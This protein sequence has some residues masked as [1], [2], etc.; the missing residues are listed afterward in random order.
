MPRLAAPGGISATAGIIV[1][2]IT[3]GIIIT[4]TGND[5]RLTPS[6]CSTP[7]FDFMRLGRLLLAFSLFST[8]RACLAADD[9]TPVP[10]T[11]TPPA[12]QKVIAARIAGGTIE[13]ID[14]SR[15]DGGIVYDID[16]ASST[17]AEGGF[18]VAADGTMLS[19]EVPLSATPPAVQKTIQTQAAGWQLEGIDKSL[20]P[21]DTSYDVEASKGAATQNFTVDDD[22]T[23]L[24]IALPLDQV[25][26]TIA[27]AIQAQARGAHIVSIDKNLD[28]TDPNYDVEVDAGGVTRS[29]ALASDATLLTSEVALAETSA[30]VQST[31]TSHARVAEIKSIDENFDPDNGNSF[32][33][34]TAPANGVNRSFTVGADGTLLSVEVT[35]DSIPPKPRNTIQNQ[36]GAGKIIRID[37]ALVEKTSGVLPYQ[38]EGR[39]DGKPFDFSVGPKGRFLGMDDGQDSGN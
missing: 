38:V 30:P 12:V 31:I 10:L 26:A 22:G 37:Q 35:L 25:P 15:E 21:D 20:E 36:I 27:S 39:K 6:H 33:V 24:S 28:D 17:G 18:S 19:V 29:F 16:F 8:A 7:K 13:G 4:T 3:I 5:R 2:T 9:S 32:D 11:Q 1:T 23:L 14:A 34:T